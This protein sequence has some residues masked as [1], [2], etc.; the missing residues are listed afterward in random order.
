MKWF[1][2][3]KY[4][5]MTGPE[6]TQTIKEESTAWKMFIALFVVVGAFLVFDMAIS[7]LVTG[8]HA[9][10]LSLSL[11]VLILQTIVLNNAK[12]ELRF[13]GLKTNE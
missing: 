1:D 6:L 13:R 12:L 9:L 10:I 8:Q 7:G 5:E 4:S 11:S 2:V 3:K